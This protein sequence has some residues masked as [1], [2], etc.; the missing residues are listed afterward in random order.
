MTSVFSSRRLALLAALA[1]SML[2]ASCKIG[3]SGSSNANL[4]AINLSDDLASV[5]LTIS[6]SVQ[7]AGLNKGVLNS[8]ASVA[9][10][11]YTVGVNS[12]G[13]S[14]TLF[15]G[16]YTFSKND[17]YTAV[18]WG[19][20][21]ALHVST[22]PEDDDTTQ[23]GT[24]NTRVRMF[25]A[26]TTTGT[27]DVYLQ[28][29]GTDLTQ[30]TPT[31]GALTSGTLAGFKEIA[32]NASYTLTVTGAGNPSDVRLVVPGI[33]LTAQQYTTFVITAGSGGVLVNATE[34][35]EQGNGTSYPN[36]QARVRLVAS[37]DGAGQVTAAVSGAKLA[38]NLQSPGIGQYVLVPAGSDAVTTSVNGNV[39]TQG[40]QTFN[41]GADY[42]LMVW[43]SAA[44]GATDPLTVTTIT[45]LNQLPTSTTRTNVRLINGAGLMDALTLSVDYAALSSSSNVLPGVAAAYQSVTSDTQAYVEVNSP[46]NGTIYASTRTNG[47]N[48]AA[49]GVYTM[50]VLGGLTPTAANPTGAKAVLRSER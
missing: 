8:Y 1:A 19:P 7:F 39:L 15:T 22:L 42:T 31:Q 27:L 46:I 16:T 20:Q 49:Q 18:V 13:N 10:N 24:G 9:T 41:A 26:T 47:D 28:P 33:A 40:P 32:Q 35:V 6:G 36:Q 30:A 23:I 50:F 29:A 44:A 43:G 45:D 34:I 4:R 2:L 5:D 25:N 38:N 21:A 17:H 3:S 12:A 11:T 37:V 48:L 14:T